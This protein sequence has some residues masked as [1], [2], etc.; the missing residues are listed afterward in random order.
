MPLPVTAIVKTVLPPHVVV[1]PLSAP[2]GRAFTVVATDAVPVQPLEF[3]TV[4][5]KFAAVLTVIVWVVAPVD[6]L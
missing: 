6:Q 5:E 4:T 1:V 2:V 3:D